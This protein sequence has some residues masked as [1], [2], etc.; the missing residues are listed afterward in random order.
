MKME[1]LYVIGH[2]IS[3]YRFAGEPPV[4]LSR[5]STVGWPLASDFLISSTLAFTP[6]VLAW[7]Q[8]IVASAAFC[9]SASVVFPAPAVLRVS[10]N[11]FRGALEGDDCWHTAAAVAS[12]IKAIKSRIVRMR[13]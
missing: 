9:N 6:G 12:P 8:R 1:L 13:G 5:Y 4:T 11:F 7:S 10:G 2:A 3:A